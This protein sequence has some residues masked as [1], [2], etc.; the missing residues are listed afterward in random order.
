M[1]GLEIVRREK[2]FDTSS[3]TRRAGHHA[4]LEGERFQRK[5]I[6]IQ[7]KVKLLKKI[8]FQGV[9]W[10]L[11]VYMHSKSKQTF[12]EEYPSRVIIYR[13]VKSTSGSQETANC[14]RMGKY[15]YW[16]MSERECSATVFR[17]Y[18]LLGWSYIWYNSA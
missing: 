10:M 7:C 13:P 12:I 17:R 11:V 6:L 15:Y 14:Q 8:T 5:Q 16:N 1:S 18:Q 9:V 2:L 3:K 4:K